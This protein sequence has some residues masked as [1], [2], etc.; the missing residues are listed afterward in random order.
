MTRSTRE[1]VVD[2]ASLREEMAGGDLGDVRLN[3]RRDRMIAALEQHPDTGFPEA[4]GED[5]ATEA[6]YRFLRNRRVSLDAILEPH[7]RAT[8]RRCQAVGEVLVV[9]DTTEHNFSGEKS[10]RGLTRLGPQRQGFW[11]HTAL[12]VSADGLRAPLGVLAVAP[13]VRK[14]RGHAGAPQPWRQRFQDPA[15][16]SRRWRDGVA[17]VRARLGPTVRATHVM[18]REGDSYELFADLI[19]HRDQFIIRIHYDR[20]VET[21]AGTTDSLYR[22]IPPTTAVCERRVDVAARQGRGR[23]RPD[24]ARHPARATRTATLQFAARPVVLQRP[25][26]CGRGIPATLHVHLIY[27]WEIDAPPGEPPIEWRLLTTAPIETAADILHVVDRYRTRWLIEEFFK[28][29]KTGCAYEARQLESLSTL[30]VALGLFV[31]I[32]WQLLL[33]R[34]LAREH[35]DVPSCVAVPSRQVEIL[36]AVSTSP[37]SPNPTVGEVLRAIARLGGHLRQ[38]GDPGWLVLARGMHALRAMETGWVAAQRHTS[39]QS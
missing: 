7:V 2:R 3:A 13:V 25:H 31:P 36:R 9:H 6:C 10:R 20:R 4:C 12:A 16:H 8:T 37:L 39:D 30:L 32:A 33:L 24:Q 5:S 14:D 23:P 35:P 26:Q 38:N 11:M 1:I 27:A 17:A 29:L 19:G 28:C 21:A 34:H 22:L 15:K 18:D